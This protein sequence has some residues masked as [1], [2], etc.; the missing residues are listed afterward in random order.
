[1]DT[2]VTPAVTPPADS[3]APIVDATPTS[4]LPS[5]VVV[6]NENALNFEL[7]DG[8]KEKHL[9]GEKILGKYDSLEQLI[10]SHKNLQ[11]KHSQYVD[12]VKTVDKDVDK[13]IADDKVKTDQTTLV[14]SL[15]PEF[16]ANNMTLTPEMEAK[17]TEAKIDIRDLKLG[18]IELRDKINSAHEV[19]GGK[20][21]YEAMMSWAKES[22]TDSQKV[23]FDG[24]ITGSMGELAIEGLNARFK[25]AQEDPNAV[26]PRFSGE[27]TIKGIQ[28]YADKRELLAD[29]K[30]IDSAAGRRDIAAQRNYKARLGATPEEVWRGR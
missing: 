18:A 26:I 25:K 10:E 20:D 22:L 8:I 24:D 30:Y 1:M 9:K 15:I 17:A 23:S 7:T 2:L 11:D 3:V 19:V 13:R 5:D 14:N 27:S 28:A 6:A 16:M 21:N 4:G 29:K 12:E